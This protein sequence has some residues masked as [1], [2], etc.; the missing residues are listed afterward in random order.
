MKNSLNYGTTYSG[1]TSQ[2]T[3]AYNAYIKKLTVGKQ[4]YTCYAS[5]MTP[6]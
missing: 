5:V 3:S 2:Q 1:Y 4:G 6:R